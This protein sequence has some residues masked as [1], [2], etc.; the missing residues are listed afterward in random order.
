MPSYKR[1]HHREHFQRLFVNSL[2]LRHLPTL[3][4]QL[5]QPGKRPRQRPV[6]DDA[7]IEAFERFVLVHVA[8]RIGAI[9]QAQR[10]ITDVLLAQRNAGIEHL[11]RLTAIKGLQN[12]FEQR[13]ALLQTLQALGQAGAVERFG[14]VRASGSCSRALSTMA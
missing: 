13:L 8:Q 9:T 5:A 10:R 2:G 11:D 4:Q 3:E 6:S 12:R 1:R 14:Q 7:V